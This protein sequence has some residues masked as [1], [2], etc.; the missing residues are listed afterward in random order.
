MIVIGLQVDLLLSADS[1]SLDEILHYGSELNNYNVSCETYYPDG[2]NSLDMNGWTI[3]QEVLHGESE[4]TKF[5]HADKL[6]RQGARLETQD[7]DGHTVLHFMTSICDSLSVKYLLNKGANCRY[8][9][10][11]CIVHQ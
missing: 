8:K 4:E 3:L 2:L 9:Q 6:L 7:Q 11:L 1:S 5:E 10:D